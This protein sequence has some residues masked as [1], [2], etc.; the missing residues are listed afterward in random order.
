MK[1]D[2]GL[3]SEA[4]LDER[5]RAYEAEYATPT[6]KLADAFQRGGSLVETEDFLQWSSLRAMSQ[7][8]SEVHDIPGEAFG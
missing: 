8:I 6:T 2:W 3:V 4:E 1:I 7:L 5:L